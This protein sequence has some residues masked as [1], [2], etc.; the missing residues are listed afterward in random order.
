MVDILGVAAGSGVDEEVL[1]KA[2]GNA[3][4]GDDPPR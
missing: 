4:G 3:A 2:S 1:G